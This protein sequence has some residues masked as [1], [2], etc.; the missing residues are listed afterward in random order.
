MLV[1][2]QVNELVSFIKYNAYLY[3]VS[4]I[5]SSLTVNESEKPTIHVITI[6]PLTANFLLLEIL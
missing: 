6:D 2:L 4:L 1:A 5:L 3:L